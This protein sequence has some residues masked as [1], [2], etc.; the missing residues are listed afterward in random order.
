M[1]G[2]DH[3]QHGIINAL[4]IITDLC[5]PLDTLHALD[6]DRMEGGHKQHN[7]TMAI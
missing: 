5:C 3:Y 6:T 2:C 1:K 4:P 7:G